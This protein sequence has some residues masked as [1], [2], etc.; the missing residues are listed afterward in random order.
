M[1]IGTTIVVNFTVNVIDEY[2][3]NYCILFKIKAT[4]CIVSN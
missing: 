3:Y 1:T 4:H 2:Y